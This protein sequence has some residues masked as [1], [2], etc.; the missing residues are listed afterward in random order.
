MYRVTE[1]NR[2]II[3]HYYDSESALVHKHLP[4]YDNDAIGSKLRSLWPRIIAEQ[5]LKLPLPGK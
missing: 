2:L 1:I 3:D 4:D 5:N